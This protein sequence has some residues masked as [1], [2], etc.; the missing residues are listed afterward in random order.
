MKNNCLLTFLLLTGFS[1]FVTAQNFS[2][3]AAEAK[4][5]SHAPLEDIEALNKEVGVLVSIPNNS[6]KVVVKIVGF[7]FAKSLMQEHFNENYLESPKFPVATFTGNFSNK[8]ILEIKTPGSYQMMVSGD[9][10]IHGIAAKRE[11]PCTILV[12][13]DGKLNVSSEFMV[14]LEDHKIKIPS[15]VGKNIA[16]EVKVSFSGILEKQQ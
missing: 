14:K 10:T 16:E 2:T 4:F 6:V 13:E 7:T 15:A 8:E 12:G 5:Y 9:L 11:I 1:S 3:R